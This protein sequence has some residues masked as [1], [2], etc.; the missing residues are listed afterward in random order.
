MDASTF[1]FEGLHSNGPAPDRA[2]KLKLYGWLVG[3]WN[4]DVTI[5]KNDGTREAM[6]GSV[7]AGWVLEGRAI[8]D[9][10][11]VP[12]LFYGTT[13]RVYDPA[14]DVWNVSWSDP[15]NQVY[16][17]LTGRAHGQEIINEGKESPSLARLYGERD[18]ARGATIR[19]TFGDIESSA[20][21][22]RSERS[23][24]GTN[25]QLQREYVGRRVSQR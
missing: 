22:W 20:F 14:L 25:W 4:L 2:E 13:L 6:H 16:L 7:H 5:H 11:A 23:I 21:R 10:F 15:M 8:Q 24:D 19:W 9:V 1:L 3:R 17:S 12:G 18:V